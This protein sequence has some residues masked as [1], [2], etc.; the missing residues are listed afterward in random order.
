MKKLIEILKILGLYKEKPI[1]YW[2]EMI[3]RGMQFQIIANHLSCSIYFLDE[4]LEDYVSLYKVSPY[5]L[6]KCIEGAHKKWKEIENED[7]KTKIKRTT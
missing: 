6:S 1:N 2:K 4:E 3:A 7:Y 5:D